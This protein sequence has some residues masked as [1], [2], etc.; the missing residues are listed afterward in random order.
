M[1]KLRLLINSVDLTSAIQEEGYFL[2]CFDGA[3]ID[4]IELVLEDPDNTITV[5]DGHDFILEDFDDSNVRYFAGI[6]V[7]VQEDTVALGKDILIIASDWKM[8]TDRSYFTA[9]YDDDT[10]KAIIQA[11]FTAAA[12]TEINTSDLVQSAQTI[13]KMV[14]RGSSLRQMLDSVSEITG[15]FWD[16]NKFKK[17][18]YRPFGDNP[19]AF[20]FTDGV[21]NNTTTFPYYRFRRNQE[22]GQFNEIEVHGGIRLSTITNQVYTGNGTRKRFTL[23]LDFTIS[24]DDYPLIIAGPEGSDPDIPTIDRN[25][26]T[27]GTPI[28]TSQTVGLEEQDSGKDV[29][30]N[31]GTAQVLWTVAPPNFPTAS[32]RISGRGFVRAGFIARDEAAIL[33]AGRVFKKVLVIPEIVDDDQAMD[34]ANAFL[35]EQGP[36]TYI[37]LLT[38]KDNIKVGD[39]IPITNVVLSLVAVSFQVHELTMRGL[40]GSTYEY[41]VRL[42]SAR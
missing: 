23:S 17:L 13:N 19:V 12:V 36:K 8:I 2:S 38:N 42:K 3:V 22:I 4:S 26:G 27:D 1:V 20:S 28:W 14:F 21:P 7:D 33:T 39:S 6:V 18:I 32:W 11:A 41:G 9:Q 10:D 30:W 40:G 29:L 31:E 35:A 16:I 24:T 5:E 37:S 25:T 15:Y 34:F